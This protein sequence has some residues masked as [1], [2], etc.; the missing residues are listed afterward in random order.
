MALVTDEI[1]GRKGAPIPVSRGELGT[2]TDAPPIQTDEPQRR[3]ISG[4][5]F[6]PADGGERARPCPRGDLQNRR[7]PSNW[8]PSQARPSINRKNSD[9][10]YVLHIHSSAK[11]L[12]AQPVDATP[13]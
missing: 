6:R 1:G 11:R 4:L 7:G 8:T 13:A 3:S 10:W 9:S 12:P 5:T 2:R